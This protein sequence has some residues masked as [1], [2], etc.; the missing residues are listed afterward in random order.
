MSA[1]Y[2]QLAA[3]PKTFL[4]RDNWMRAILA[5]DLPHVVVRLAIRIALHLHVNTGRCDPGYDALAAELRVSKRSIIR[6]VAMLERTGWLAISRQYGRGKLANF[7]LVSPSEKVTTAP[8]ALSPFKSEKVTNSNVKGDKALSPFE[9]EKVTTRCHPIKRRKKERGKAVESQTLPPTRF[10]E[11]NKRSSEEENTLF[12]KTES[13]PQAPR[14]EKADC[15]SQ[16]CEM[17]SG[18]FDRFWAAY[19]RRVAK[20]AARKAFEAAIKG[21][22]A[23]EALIEGARRY[24][25]ERAGQEPRYTKH[26]A[27]WL[28]GGCWEDEAPPQADGPPI[29]DGVTG[30]V[31]PTPA[32]RRN[33]HA[34]TWDDFLAEQLALHCP[35]EVRHGQ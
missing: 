9:A 2:R 20:E 33:G 24:A 35:E 32:P 25:G 17:Q 26:P 11:K 14:K 15:K 3:S 31:V 23:V 12:G 29:I 18:E 1:T 34:P 6:M 27:T 19:P 28:H 7:Y 5:A 8:A 22:T 16:A 13:E 30:E 10:A 21:G 4:D